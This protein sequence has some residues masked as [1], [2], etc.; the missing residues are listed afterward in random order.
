MADRALYYPYIHIRDVEWLKATLLLFRQV[1]RMTPYGPQADD[2][3]ILPFTDWHGGEEPMLTS[4]GL[5]AERP[6]AAQ[7]E[8]ARRLRG[9]ADDLDFRN[10]FS[11]HAAEAIPSTDGHGFQI[12]QAKLH[13]SLKDVLRD[14]GLAWEPGNPEPY[15]LWLDYVEVH[16][17]IGE[18]VMATLAIACAMGEGLDIVGDK[19]SGPLHDCLTRKQPK[20][21]YDAWLKPAS[22][23]T[24]P[25]Q[26]DARELFEF[27]VYMACDTTKLDVQALAEMGANRDPIRRLMDALAERAKDMVAMDPGKE[28]TEQFR[29]ETAKILNTW[30]NDRINM[31]NYWKKF[32]SLGLMEPGGKLL[33]KVIGKAAE[34]TP[35]AAAG[36]TGALAGLA[37]HAPLLASGAGLGI[38]LFTHAAK[39]YVDL[40]S[41]DRESPYRYLTLLE[42]T[43]VVIRADLR[44]SPG[45]GD[46][47]HDHVPLS[48]DPVSS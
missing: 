6:A 20:D 38:G 32:F 37:L 16:P 43:G 10:R 33:E 42:G 35:A 24:D 12:H 3:Q 7:V 11:R 17:R 8:L 30:A 34:A 46:R 2:G 27:L 28:R 22:K 41:Q 5:W 48:L 26:A 23:I 1:R 25:P 39:T 29:D 15:D 19:R 40:R 45:R 18:A 14:T 21:V 13:P 31:G 9:D 4:A 44:G 36:A 47:G